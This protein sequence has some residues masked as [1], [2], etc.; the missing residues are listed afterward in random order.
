MIKELYQLIKQR[1][2][3]ITELKEVDLYLGQ[4]EQDGDV[5]LYQAPAVYIEFDP[6]SFNQHSKGVQNAQVLFTV[7]LVSEALGADDR[8]I[9]DNGVINHM[10]LL[11]DIFVALQG[12]VGLLSNLPAFASLAGTPQDF[13]VINSIVRTGFEMLQ[14]PP[15]NLYVSLQTFEFNWFDTTAC[16]EL[17]DVTVD[18]VNI[19]ANI[20]NQI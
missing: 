8:K 10:G 13:T 12:Y 19:D 6:I 20:V 16:P 3:T 1:L 2:Q 18:D 5:T 17:T 7:Y 11:D 4:F 9:L 14:T 15:S